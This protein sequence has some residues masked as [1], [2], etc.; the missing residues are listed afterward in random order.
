MHY[1]V[2]EGSYSIHPEICQER[3]LEFAKLVQD[4]HKE[5]I[6]VTIDVVYNHIYVKEDSILDNLVPNY[7]F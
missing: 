4:C 6:K 2:V 3:I 5:N 1:R 7:Y